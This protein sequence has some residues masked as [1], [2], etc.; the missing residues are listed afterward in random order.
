MAS[1]MPVSRAS[2][3]GAVGGQLAEAGEQG[4]HLAGGGRHLHLSLVFSFIS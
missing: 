2:R 1:T 3:E 4:E